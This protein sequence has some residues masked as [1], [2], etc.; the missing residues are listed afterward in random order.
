MASEM[1]NE[2]PAYKPRLN[3]DTMGFILAS[4]STLDLLRCACVCTTLRQLCDAILWDG[5]VLQLS[6]TDV[7]GPQLLWLCLLYTSPSP[8]D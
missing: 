3:A 8:R 4:V 7:S 6:G 5:R 2:Q 1:D